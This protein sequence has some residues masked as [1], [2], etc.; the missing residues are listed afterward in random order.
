MH[1]KRHF[2]LLFFVSIN[3][4]LTH[5]IQYFRAHVLMMVMSDISLEPG[6]HKITFT[7]TIACAVQA[8]RSLK[9]D[10]GADYMEIFQQG[11]SYPG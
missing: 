6:E 1:G 2:E 11:L 5:F 7:V 3:E 10:L 9:L 4:T 8:G